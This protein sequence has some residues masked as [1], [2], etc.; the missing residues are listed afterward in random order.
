MGFPKDNVQNSDYAKASVF[1]SPSAPSLPSVNLTSNHKGVVEEE[2]QVALYNND[3]GTVPDA[4]YMQHLEHHKIEQ[5]ENPHL[6][7]FLSHG[8]SYLGSKHR[9]MASS[10]S[11]QVAGQDSYY[12]ESLHSARSSSP[13][14]IG[15]LNKYDITANPSTPTY[16]IPASTFT[17]VESLES[18]ARAYNVSSPLFIKVAPTEGNDRIHNVPNPPHIKAE[19]T[20]S[21]AGADNVF[22]PPFVKI[23]P[24]DTVDPAL[25][26]PHPPL[27]KTELMERSAFSANAIG[28]P[29]S[30]TFSSLELIYPMDVMQ[31]LDA[32][33]ERIARVLEPLGDVQCLSGFDRL[34]SDVSLTNHDDEDFFTG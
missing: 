3:S 10:T 29:Q 13:R 27:I 31:I 19:P 8:S 6:V 12:D 26:W 30:T 2:Y 7:H 11:S 28:N 22:A 24:M 5:A 32:Q 4:L 33:S 15:F 16:D 34:S 25:D 20:E 17:K 23:E 1:E 21:S 14:T 18:N 9:W